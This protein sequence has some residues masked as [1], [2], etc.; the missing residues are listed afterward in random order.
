MVVEER[1]RAS[2]AAAQYGGDV[3]SGNA[4]GTMWWCCAL[5]E[6]GRRHGVLRVL[7]LGNLDTIFVVDLRG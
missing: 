6:R 2:A 3:L 4:D 5:R 1:G 7:R